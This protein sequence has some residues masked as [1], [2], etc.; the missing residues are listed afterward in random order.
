MQAAGRLY[1]VRHGQSQW[2]LQNRIAGQLDPELSE[3]GREQSKTLANVLRDE[4]LAAIYTSKLRRTITTASPL[5]QARGLPISSLDALNE[6][7]F[8]ILQGRH[9]DSRDPEAASMW[10]AL[11]H[12]W[13]GFEAPGRETPTQLTQRVLPC[14]EQ[15]L[16]AH[17]GEDILIVGHR[18]TNQVILG[19][20]M[21]WPVQQWWEV[22]IRSKYLYRID[23]GTE[24]RVTTTVLLGAATG[25]C[26]EGLVTD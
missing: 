11:N 19:S 25:Q 15:L 26:K 21:K 23:T 10:Q 24:P 8:G 7:S 18:H 2:N 20:L 14:L 13:H 5:A 22:N 3:R 6:I 1:L 17:S 12:D 4:Q 9:R 16:A